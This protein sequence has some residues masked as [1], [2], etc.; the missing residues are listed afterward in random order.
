MAILTIFLHDK[1]FQCLKRAVPSRSHSRSV[2]SEAT[3]YANYLEPAF[4]TNIIRCDE[5]EARNLLLYV[6]D[7]PEVVTAVA[8]AFQNA[9]VSVEDERDTIGEMTSA[10]RFTRRWH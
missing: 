7:C 5:T 10:R 2:L 8:H 1:A 3:R 6:R 4:G 9:G